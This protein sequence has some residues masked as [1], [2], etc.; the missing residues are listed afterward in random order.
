MSVK[1]KNK[2]HDLY[3]VKRRRRPSGDK[4]KN[5]QV[6]LVKVDKLLVKEPAN[7]NYQNRK[8]VALAKLKRY[9]FKLAVPL[10]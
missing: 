7:R 3:N 1:R 9:G 2:S 5:T 4:I 8:K 6:A 10:H